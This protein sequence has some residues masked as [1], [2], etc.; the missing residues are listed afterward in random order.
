MVIPLLGIPSWWVRPGRPRL[1]TLWDCFSTGDRVR[2]TSHNH[3]KRV[4]GCFQ[5]LPISSILVENHTPNHVAETLFPRL[6]VTTTPHCTPASPIKEPNWAASTWRSHPDP[7]VCGPLYD[8]LRWPE[9]HHLQHEI[10]LH[11]RSASWPS[12]S[13]VSGSYMVFMVPFCPCWRLSRC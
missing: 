13:T 12:Y 4:T 10:H 5:F 11:H 3:R 8:K 1:K 2:I 9:N 6:L 7:P